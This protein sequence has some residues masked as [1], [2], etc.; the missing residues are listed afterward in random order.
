MRVGIVRNDIGSVYLADLRPNNQRSFT[1][2]SPGQARVIRKPTDA[3]LAQAMVDGGGGTAVTVSALKA[4]VYPT[5]TT[6]DVSSATI[7][8]LSGTWGALT[9][10]EQ[11]ILVAAIA[12]QVAPELVETG[13]AQL[14][15]YSGVMK[16]LRDAAFQPGGTRVGLPAGQAI[17]VVENDGST[18]F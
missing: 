2:S 6:I 14:S 4:A 10:P 18:P 9:A 17:A 1:Q 5:A 12:D 8:G 3:E 16:E 15:F 11:A 13:Y 7:I